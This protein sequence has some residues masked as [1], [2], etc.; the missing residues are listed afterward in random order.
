MLSV[1]TS[2]NFWFS[3][4]ASTTPVLL[5]TLAANMVFQA[6]MFNLA[7]EGTML[8]CALTGVLVSVYTKNLFISVLASVL[9]GI[10]ISFI[11][12][13]FT[14]I[15]N[16]PMNACGVAINLLAS[17]G[18]VFVLV[19]TAGS[20]ITSLSLRSLTFPNVRIPFLEKIP[21]VGEVL[22]GQNFIT[23]L[24]LLFVVLTWI[25]LYRMPAGRNLRA[26]GKNPDAAQSVGISVLK[27]K[28]L[29]L[30]FCGTFS[31]F[32]GMYLSMGSL[33]SFT[34]NMTNGRGFLSLAMNAMSKG[35]PV[36]GFL[37]SLLYG[38]SDTTTVYLQLYTNMDVKLISALP[39]VFVLVV[40]VIVESIKARLLKRITGSSAVKKGVQ[41]M[42]NEP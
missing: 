32:G 8:I 1:F 41:Q 9:M 22:S 7:I 25:F 24:G 39:Y 35:N 10:L 3:V 30:A 33:S 14:L 11:L 23:Y 37:S 34:A 28:F 40:L 5:A 18:T 26:V 2:L 21:V 42:K 13:Y 19:L 29:A 6:G 16:G 17:G 20:K 4:L 36:V 12:G 27:M 31:A 15:M 38:F